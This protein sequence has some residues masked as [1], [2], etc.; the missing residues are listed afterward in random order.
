MKNQP[1]TITAVK[2]PVMRPLTMKEFDTKDPLSFAV[3]EMQ[4]KQPLPRRSRSNRIHFFFS[5]KLNDTFAQ[6][7]CVCKWIIWKI[8]YLNCRERY[9]DMIEGCSWTHN[10]SSCKIKARKDFRPKQ[11]LNPWPLW[12]WW[13]ALITELSNHLGVN[14]IVSS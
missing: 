14:H 9:E 7:L 3:N 1:Y 4:L 12:Y 2:L 11:N 13:S 6:L 5:K 8:V 10:L